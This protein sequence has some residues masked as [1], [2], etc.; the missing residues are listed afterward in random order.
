MIRGV[1]R[2]ILSISISTVISATLCTELSISSCAVAA[3]IAVTVT[4]DGKFVQ[5]AVIIAVPSSPPSGGFPSRPSELRATI[6]QTNKQFVPF[7]TVVRVGTTVSFPNNDDVKHHVYSFSLAKRFELPLYAGKTSPPVLFDQ[8]GPV[9]L[10]CNIHDWM[11]AYIYVSESPYFSLTDAKGA[12]RIS[13]MPAGSYHVRLWHPN[14]ATPEA[15]TI[16]LVEVGSTTS[17]LSWNIKLRPETRVNRSAPSM[18][19]GSHY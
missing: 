9:V 12:A 13:T 17:L 14:L 16:R 15:D 2:S 11:L 3:D 8:S 18:G 19:H 5:D 1:L 10:G 4:S 6:N 7:V